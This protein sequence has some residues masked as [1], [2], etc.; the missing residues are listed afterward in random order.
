MRAQTILQTGPIANSL[1]TS[2]LQ[3][4]EA[5]YALTMKHYVE[6]ILPFLEEERVSDIYTNPS[7]C[8]VWLG[9]SEGREQTGITMLETH[10][11]AFL[12][13]CAERQNETLDRKHEHIQAQLPLAIF[14]GA[15]LQGVT[16]RI[17]ERPCFNLRK[18]ASAIYPLEDYLEKGTLCPAHY[19]AIR[20]AIRERKNILVFGGMGSGKTTLVNAI[21]N[22]MV[23]ED[24]GED[25]L[26]LE[27]TQELQSRAPGTRYLTQTHEND[28][29]DLVKL[30]KRMF[31]G[32]IIVG[33]VRDEAA[34]DLMNAWTSGH[35]G[36]TGTVHASSPVGALRKMASLARWAA[37]TDHAAT[38]AEAIDL[39]V[40][41][42]QSPT[43]RAVRQVAWV[44]DE[45]DEDGNYILEV[46][47]QLQPVRLIPTSDPPHQNV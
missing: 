10:I 29:R 19:E 13:T 7:T 34:L 1:M 46:V 30:T 41:I 39:V 31:P 43:G 44:G 21:L 33:E 11:R 47:P 38:V 27:D 6:P 16:P 26:I 2:S 28:L 25:F 12:N 40:G 15:R 36:G 8:E 32:R 18:R 14:R 3:T 37:D 45:L 20:T 5:Q 17:V 23:D 4:R 22:G 42:E 35:P 9:T 24:P